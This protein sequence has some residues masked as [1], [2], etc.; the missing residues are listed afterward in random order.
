[1]SYFISCIYHSTT[2][3]LPLYQKHHGIRK[4]KKGGL[5]IKTD[6]LFYRRFAE[7]P[8]AELTDRENGSMPT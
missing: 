8:V 2:L 4:R 1:M 7:T 6:R 3:Y 5:G